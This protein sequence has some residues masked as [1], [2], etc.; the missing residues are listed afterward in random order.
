[1]L[2]LIK[3]F[4]LKSFVEY[5]IHLLA[6]FQKIAGWQANVI[7]M[8]L[9]WKE[10]WTTCEC[11][12]FLMQA[13]SEHSGRRYTWD[14]GSPRASSP[15][16][17]CGCSQRPAGVFPG[18]KPTISCG[19]GP[20]EEMVYL[21]HTGGGMNTAEQCLKCFNTS[22]VF[23]HFLSSPVEGSSVSLGKVLGTF[24]PLWNAVLSPPGFLNWGELAW[25]HLSSEIHIVLYLCKVDFGTY[26]IK[27]FKF[28]RQF[29]G[30]L[31]ILWVTVI[32][33]GS[34]V[35]SLLTLCREKR[36]VCH[37]NCN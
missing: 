12:M 1:M 19:N 21:N 35:A 29:V 23:I 14:T 36:E 17:Q 10:K 3:Q 31:W 4:L 34:W 37:V 16:S 32:K 25:K 9:C 8:L 30:A 20:L 13:I 15:L 27:V 24:V 7:I 5:C 2:R 33:T 26:H 11:A 6:S 18:G 28:M 22:I